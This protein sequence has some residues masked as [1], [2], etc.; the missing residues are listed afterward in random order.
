MAIDE[1]GD[2]SGAQIDK[3]MMD[4]KL[5]MSNYIALDR[6]KTEYEDTWEVK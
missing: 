5:S 4:Y 2:N 3:A 1:R 6:D